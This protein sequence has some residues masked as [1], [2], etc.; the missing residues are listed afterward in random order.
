MRRKNPVTKSAKKSGGPKIKIREKSVLPKPDPN[1][2]QKKSTFR[3]RLN[4]SSEKEIFER[5]TH[6]GPIF[7]EEV[8]TSRLKFS[9]DIKNF[10]RD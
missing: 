7:G 5:A 4:I 2:D 10:D 8:E 6:R 1:K 3:A 9:S